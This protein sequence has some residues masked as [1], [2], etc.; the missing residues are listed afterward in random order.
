[1]ILAKNNINPTVAVAAVITACLNVF[2]HCVSAQAVN[3][4]LKFNQKSSAMTIKRNTL[5]DFRLS[6]AQRFFEREET[7]E[8]I[9]ENNLSVSKNDLTIPIRNQPQI[10]QSF[11]GQASWYG[12]KFHGR[13][14]ASGEIFNQNAFTAAHRYLPFGTR[15]KVTNINNGR[16][17]IVRINDRG[18]FT[19]GRIIDLSAAAARSIGLIRTGVAPVQVSV[20][21]G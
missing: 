17:V 18:P 5:L 7:T 2:P 8:F 1:M 9:D 3:Q 11:S 13:Q 15:V 20:L 16:S 21:G 14:T 10:A 6:S 19:K 4:N 12:G